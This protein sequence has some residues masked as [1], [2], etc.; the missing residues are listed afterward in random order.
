MRS[1]LD[2]REHCLIE[3]NFHDPYMKQKQMEN[4]EALALLQDRLASLENLPFDELHEQLA[5]G[6]LA[7]NVFDWGAKEVALLMESGQGL[8]FEDALKFVNPRPWLVDNLDEWKE[9]L[10]KQP[11]HKCAAIFIDNSGVDIILGIIPFATELLK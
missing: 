1:L 6:V 10:Q 8:K 2:M 4:Q 11:P 9:R 7:G 5:L 3:F